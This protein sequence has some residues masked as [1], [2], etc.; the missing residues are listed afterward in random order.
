MNLL[1]QLSFQVI[2]GIVIGIFLGM[3]AP[4]L[5]VSF[6]PFADLF[7]KLIKMMITPIIFFTLVSGIAAIS[8][9]KTVGK[10][11]GISLIYFLFTTTCALALGLVVANLFHPGT[12]MNI[13][14]ASLNLS[15]ASTYLGKA[16]QIDN[17][18]DFILNII[19]ETFFSALIHGEI[20]QVL[21]VAI[22]FALGLMSYGSKGK[23]ILESFEHVTKIFFNIIHAMM[24]Y[25]P[26]AA[27][28]AMAYTVGQYGAHSLIGLTELLLCFYLTCIVFIVV[29]LGMIVYFFL[30]LNILKVI[31]YFKTEIFI[32]FAT[33]SSETVM[34]NLLEKLNELG[35]DKSVVDLVIPTGYSFNLDGTAIYLTLAALFIAQATNSD[36][37]LNQQIFLLLIMIISSKGA[38]GVTGSGFIILASSLAA[39]GTIPVAGVVIILGVDRFMSSGRSLTN[40]MGNA[41]AALIISKWQNSINMKRVHEKLP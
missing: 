20:L 14:P 17:V 13:D 30:G 36:I 19:P 9:L 5:A 3:L 8:D 33:S 41:I 22:V 28:A 32:V 4:N 24:H 2:A 29:L 11:G 16:E 21:F 1:K 37:T 7:I 27:F 34:P 15:E 39:V 12:G 40:M 6:K 38:A 26:I 23:F 25:A 18:Q 35:C 31:Q 10:I